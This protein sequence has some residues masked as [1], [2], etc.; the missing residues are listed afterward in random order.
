VETALGGPEA[1]DVE[2]LVDRDEVQEE[3]SDELEE[4][5]LLPLP[6]GGF[7]D[8]AVDNVMDVHRINL[9]RWNVYRLSSYRYRVEI[10]KKY[11]IAFACLIFILLGAPLAMRFPHGGAGMAIAASVG[12]F[13][14]YWMGLIGGERFADRGQMNPILAMWLPNAILLALAVYFLKTMARQI[15]TNRGSAWRQFRLGV[16]GRVRGLLP[17]RTPDPVEEGA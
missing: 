8:A 5:V 10:H 17:G 2:G 15:S 14:F 12:I 4:E 3:L 11:A 7:M 6:E 13:F 16:S 1:T 9:T